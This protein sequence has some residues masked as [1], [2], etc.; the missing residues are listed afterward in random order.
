M[1]FGKNLTTLGEPP[2]STMVQGLKGVRAAGFGKLMLLLLLVPI[3]GFGIWAYGC[4][5][6]YYQMPPMDPRGA[7]CFEC[8][9]VT[10][11]AD[12]VFETT[13]PIGDGSQP[14]DLCGC[15]DLSKMP[16]E[17]LPRSWAFCIHAFFCSDKLFD[18]LFFIWRYFALGDLSKQGLKSCTSQ[19][20]QGMILS[21]HLS[22]GSD[23][24]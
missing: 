9:K 13:S 24:P 20:R 2:I 11:L 18:I 22:F 10:Y 8:K 15:R 23:L 16:E 4:Y 6:W 21:D 19:F 12:R 1:G 5:V 7:Y 3:A 17:S 14:C